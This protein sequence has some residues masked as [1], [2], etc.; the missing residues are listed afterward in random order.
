MSSYCLLSHYNLISFALIVSIMQPS[1]VWLAISLVISFVL[2]IFVIFLREI[3]MLGVYCGDCGEWG[4]WV[5]VA[6]FGW[7]LRF[8]CRILLGSI[9][10]CRVILNLCMS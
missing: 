1:S 9:L 6:G 10:G 7:V 4:L 3:I 8:G 2:A 5:F